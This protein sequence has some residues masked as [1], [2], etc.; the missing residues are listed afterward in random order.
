MLK[1]LLRLKRFVLPYRWRLS[2]GIIAFGIARLF[3]GLVPILLAI[4]IDRFGASA[5][6]GT[7]LKKYGMKAATIVS[8]AMQLLS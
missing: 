3:E 4:G 2:G 8:K 5:P 7:I 6:G 1:S